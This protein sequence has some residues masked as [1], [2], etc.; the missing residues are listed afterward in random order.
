MRGM[1]S[2]WGQRRRVCIGGCVFVA[3]VAIW[4]SVPAVA[5]PSSTSLC[6]SV[7]ASTVSRVVGR[8]TAFLP[9]KGLLQN[10]GN[11]SLYFTRDTYLGIGLTGGLDCVYEGF[12][13]FVDVVLRSERL[14]E[15]ALPFFKKL[16]AESTYADPPPKAFHGLGFPAY[17]QIGLSSFYYPLAGPPIKTVT[18][19]VVG[20]KGDRLLEVFI[21]HAIPVANA[22]LR[23]DATEL[24]P[25]MRL[26]LKLH[27]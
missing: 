8:K 2:G 14:P 12:P 27:P 20:A 7:A 22:E 26:A 3:A 24:G 25:L 19:T 23:A 10:F 5:S 16:V 1:W 15:P 6:E 11:G 17:E 13:P 21:L 9:Y 18:S 4:S